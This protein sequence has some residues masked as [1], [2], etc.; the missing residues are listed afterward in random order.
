MCLSDKA[1]ILGSWVDE[2]LSEKWLLSYQCDNV[3]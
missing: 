2:G 1:A 3:N